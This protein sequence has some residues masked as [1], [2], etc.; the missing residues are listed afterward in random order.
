MYINVKSK[1]NKIMWIEMNFI[2]I[3]IKFNLNAFQLVAFASFLNKP[4]SVDKE[5][6][7][8]P[9]FAVKGIIKNEN[10]KEYMFLGFIF[11]RYFAW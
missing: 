5:K 7:D 11:I 2:W 8:I 10:K 4:I 1:W 9:T 3:K 6:K